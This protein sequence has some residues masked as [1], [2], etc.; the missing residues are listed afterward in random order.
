MKNNGRYVISV[1]G[2]L[3]GCYP[4]EFESNSRNTR[5]HINEYGADFCCVRNKSGMLIT[6]A[7][8]WADGTISTV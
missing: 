2:G 7:R 6:S 8:K 4:I 5:R 3:V 1:W